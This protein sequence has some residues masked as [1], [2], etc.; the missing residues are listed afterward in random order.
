MI[1]RWFLQHFDTLVAAIATSVAA[2]FAYRSAK[3]SEQ[4]NKAQ[5]SPLLIPIKIDYIPEGSHQVNNKPNKSAF[6]ITIENRTEYKNAFAKNISIEINEDLRWKVDT[7]NPDKM[8]YLS[9]EDIS[10]DKFLS[11]ILSI[12]YFD[13]LGNKFETICNLSN[14]IVKES[15]IHH[16]ATFVGFDWKYIQK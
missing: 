4:A 5:F 7:L 16:E 3:M 12:K 15:P 6:S 8:A 2:F 1:Y 14:E 10:K 11:K 13:I 9:R